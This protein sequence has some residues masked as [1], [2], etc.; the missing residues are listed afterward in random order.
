MEGMLDES[1]PLL[2]HVVEYEYTTTENPIVD[3][4]RKG[5]DEENPMDWSP[6]YKRG[7]VL[8]LAFMAF[9]VTFTCIGVVPIADKIILNL[10]GA[11]NTSSSILLVSIWEL[12]EAFGPLL[13]A[14]LS[15]IYGRYPIF[16]IA[17]ILFIIATAL[18]ATASSSKTLIFARFLT[19]CATASNVLNPSIIADIFPVEEQGKGMSLVMLAPL[20]G[21]AIGPALSGAIAERFGWRIVLWGSAV[22]AIIC[23]LFFFFLFRETYKVPILQRRAARLR[24]ETGNANWKCAWEGDSDAS[25]SGWRILW[26]SVKRPLSVLRSSVVLQIMS[27]YGGLTFSSFYILATTLPRILSRVY[28]FSPALVGSSFLCFS[29]GAT[30]GVTIS[31]LFSDK[32]YLTLGTRPHH[33]PVPEYRLPL[34]ILGASLMPFV[35]ALYGWTP[36]ALWSVSLILLAAALLGTIMMLIWVPLSLY[37]VESFG[38][39]SAS[40]MTM[41]LVARCLGGTLLPLGIPPL[42]GRLGIGPGFLVLAAVCGVLIPVPVVVMRCGGVW[43]RWSRFS[44]GE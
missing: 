22:V 16:N 38:L 2:G 17:N 9:T 23:E 14:P 33:H 29:T 36:H 30:L 11:E 42:T 34:M 19:G 1:Q 12:G 32:I 44:R 26:T 28:G 8:L 25:S 6:A 35:A 21:G 31:N 41:V 27:F 18:S 10:D 20:L 37:V 7:I 15:E 13:I 40:A 3:F 5:R 39:Y 24:K 4:N 43:R